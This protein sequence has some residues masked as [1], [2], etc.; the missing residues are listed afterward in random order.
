MIPGALSESKKA[1]SEI[2]DLVD[3]IKPEVEHKT[4][5]TYSELRAVTYKMQIVAGVN[6]FVSVATNNESNEVIFLK[7]H[8][9]LHG[10]NNDLALTAYQTGKSATDEI[11]PF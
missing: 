3:R 9:P 8:K 2:Q 4:N 7:I 5:T 11:T 10:S 1:T 6:Y